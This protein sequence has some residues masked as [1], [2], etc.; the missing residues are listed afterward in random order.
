MVDTCGGRNAEGWVPVERRWLG[1]DRRSLTPTIMVAAIAVLLT[2]VVPLIDR[3]V[4]QDD[5]IRAGE[6]LDLGGGIVVTPPAGWEL[7][8]GIRV[9]DKTTVPVTAG[10]ADAAFSGDG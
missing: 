3:A 5:P 2:F 1:L 10:T 8:S 4:P 7:E 6:R 9:G